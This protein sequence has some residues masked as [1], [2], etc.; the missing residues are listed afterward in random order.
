M[1]RPVLVLAGGV[2]VAFALSACAVGPD[3]VAPERPTPPGFHAPLER[4]LVA[5]PAELARWWESFGDRALI[6]LVETAV[7]RNPGLGIA[8]ARVREA[9]FR[10]TVASG[11]LGP[12]LDANGGVQRSEYS[13]NE[14]FNFIQGPQDLWSAGFDAA[15]E[16][17]VFGGARRSAE[18][19]DAEF[20]V[21]VEEY[22]DVLVSL[23]AEVARNYVE[24]RSAQERLAI[25]LAN[26]RAQRETLEITVSRLGAGLVTELD[27]AQARSNLASTR[28]RVPPLRLE[29]SAADGR[30]AVLLGIDPGRLAE[31]VPGLDAQAPLPR[32]PA[33][34]AVGVPAELLRRRPDLRRAEREVA[35][36]CAAIGIATAEL[37]PQ[38]SLTGSIGVRSRDAD[39][40]F[41]QDSLRYAFGPGF[42][43]NL[44][45]MGRVRAAVNAAEEVHR[46]SLARYEQSVL[47]ALD[48]TRNTL[49]GFV[50]EQ[51][52]LEILRE[53][54]ASSQQAVELARELYARGVADFQTVLDAERSLFLTQEQ[55]AQSERS[56]VTGLIAL[57]KALGGGWEALAPSVAGDSGPD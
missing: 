53:G 33:H 15:W 46:Q 6:A 14:I 4:G 32:V 7:Q 22:R 29:L 13:E 48:E 5:E 51:E 57:F 36:A 20:G 1:R 9:R 47:G 44:F 28:S 56:V 8:A 11:A 12:T 43:W 55:R 26:E 30:L 50:R 3:H 54:E 21:R 31:L 25:A 24:L 19:A 35:A 41:E 34:I 18:A 39:T 40:L 27:V 45:A 16:I 49:L 2:V 23:I 38:F 10:R 37:Y 17:D 52:R 42:R